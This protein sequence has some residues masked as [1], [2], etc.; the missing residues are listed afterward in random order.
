MNS[1]TVGIATYNRQRI[2]GR[3]IEALLEQDLLPERIIIFDSSENDETAKIVALF[4]ASQIE[5]I[6]KPNRTILPI[7]RNKILERTHTEIIT[8][9]DD[10]VVATP[11]FLKNISEGFSELPEIA[12][13]TGPTISATE[14]LEPIEK[15]IYDAKNRT[16]ILP[17]GEIRSDTRCW[18][19]PR[20]LYCKTLIGANMSYRTKLLRKMDGFDENYFN[21]SFREESDV[22]MR[23]LRLGYKFLYHPGAFVYHIV[24]Q[25]GGIEDIESQRTQYFYLAGKNHRYFCDKYFPKW[26]TRT[27]WLF[28][29]RNPPCLWLALLRTIIER[30]N[31]LAW[32]MGLWSIG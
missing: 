20:P 19:P 26:L 12:G 27:A 5:Y 21:P 9:I 14:D 11:E 1:I 2:I 22:Q 24:R 17:W 25:S 10:D 28:W 23:L 30:K 8:F 7:A 29:N 16:K 3:C 18:I 32:H 31:Y 6:H 4:G 13:I 15:L